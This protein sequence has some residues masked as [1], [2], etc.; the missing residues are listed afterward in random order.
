MKK[1]GNVFILGDSYSTFE[2]AIEKECW[3]WYYK[4]PQND[5]DVCKAEQT[6]WMQLLKHTDSNLVR[7][8]SFSGTTI[9][10]TDW[11][12]AD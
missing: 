8:S 3:L 12:N 4:E 10:H 1:L 11:N 2:G 9:Y 6:W 7:N 5:T